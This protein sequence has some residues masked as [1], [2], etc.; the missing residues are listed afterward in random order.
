MNFE[1]KQFCRLFISFILIFSSFSFGIDRFKSLTTF[2]TGNGFSAPLFTG[3]DLDG[4]EISLNDYQGQNVLV[5]F[6]SPSCPHCKKKVPLL[7]SIVQDGDLKVVMV[8]SANAE[9]ANE[10]KNA[11]GAKFEIIADGDFKITRAYGVKAVPQG[12]LIDSES[13]IISST[14]SDGSSFWNQLAGN[15]TSAASLQIESTR[16][17][18]EGG[19]NFSNGIVNA[20]IRGEAC[21]SD[22]DCQNVG[23]FVARGYCSENGHCVYEAVDPTKCIIRESYLYYHIYHVMDWIT[24]CGGCQPSHNQ[25]G[26]TP[27]VTDDSNCGSYGSGYCMSGYCVYGNLAD[28][29]L[30]YS[31]GE[32]TVLYN[33]C[34]INGKCYLAG[35]VNP[36]NPCEQ[37]NPFES[38]HFWTY[39]DDLP[40]DDG[41]NCT[42]DDHCAS[43][44][45]WGTAYTC[46]DWLDC[47]INHCDGN[48]GCYYRTDDEHCLINGQCVAAGT[49]NPSHQCESCIPALSKTIWSNDDSLSC[50]DGDY[51]TRDDHCSSGTCVG[52]NFECGD[53]LS[54]TVDTCMGDGTCMHI[55]QE[56]TCLIMGECYNRNAV[57]PNDSCKICRDDKGEYYKTHWYM[58]DMD[59]D[60]ICDLTDN[61]LRVPNADQDDWDNDGKGDRCDAIGYLSAWGKNNYNQSNELTDSAYT[62]V[63]AGIDSSIA[64]K[65]DGS[66]KGWGRD[67][68]GEK[69]YRPGGT[70]FVAISLKCYHCLALRA[71]GSVVAWGGSSDY[72]QTTPPVRY[73]IVAIATGL[74]HSIALTQAGYI[75]GWG[76]NYYGQ[77]TVPTG[78][79]FVAISANNNHNVALRSNGTIVSWGNNGSGQVTNTPTGSDFIAV[80]A[81]VGYS[82]A[83]KADGSIVA[84]GSLSTTTNLPPTGNN[85]VAISAGNYNNLALKSDGT[86]AAWGENTDGETS[87]LPP[88]NT[89]TAIS[90]GNLFNT[91]IMNCT[92][93]LSG[94]INHDCYTNMKD[95]RVLSLEWLNSTGTLTSDIDRN[96]AVNLSDFSLFAEDWM[97]CSYPFDSKCQ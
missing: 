73:D 33:H 96:N 90:A 86:L 64:L 97:L 24:D 3:F 95:L 67:R 22:E 37:C 46:D 4:K 10:F 32:E 87:P 38:E 53:E 16:E 41:D 18:G 36:L 39:N 50:T 23:P 71:N 82:L 55:I 8:L 19:I 65:A 21:S 85:F 66:I 35:D 20:P 15:N 26:I 1:K 13:K 42:H 11:Q 70:G 58:P 2:G 94:D 63:E 14:I 61:C 79:D 77:I 51:C 76:D 30:L 74:Y 25:Y 92:E 49:V 68:Y 56:G 83:L 62:A 17:S 80:S 7:N 5:V 78:N 48:G 31:G 91:A 88:G 12:F 27:W 40:C 84:W 47:T 29:C 57:N 93:M 69:S 75:I 54:C 6:A 28:Y 45:C 60:G 9:K 59:G 34:Y 44:I 81:G 52:T 72:G 43:G 89:Y